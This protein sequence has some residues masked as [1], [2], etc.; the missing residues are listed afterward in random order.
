MANLPFWLPSAGLS[1]LSNDTD[2]EPTLSWLL[3]SDRPGNTCGIPS[4]VTGGMSGPR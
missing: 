1:P 2:F 3:Q 4:Y